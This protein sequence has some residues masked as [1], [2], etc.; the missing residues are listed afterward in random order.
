[1]LFRLPEP[2]RAGMTKCEGFFRG[3]TIFKEYALITIFSYANKTGG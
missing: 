3:G 2:V 1:V